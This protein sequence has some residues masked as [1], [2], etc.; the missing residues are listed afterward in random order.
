MERGEGR[1]ER[2]CILAQASCGIDRI[3]RT[4]DVTLGVITIKCAE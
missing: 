3:G 1:G 2:G 4:I